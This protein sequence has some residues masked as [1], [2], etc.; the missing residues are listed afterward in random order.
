MQNVTCSCG[1]ILPVIPG[2]EGKSMPCPKCGQSVPFPEKEDPP[3]AAKDARNRFG[4][5][6]VSLDLI[7]PIQLEKALQEQKTLADRAER[8]LLGEILLKKDF[9]TAEGVRRVL[10]S[11]G[12]TLYRCPK[13]DRGYNVRGMP[14]GRRFRCKNCG[15]MI[16]G[17]DR[18]DD[19][20]AVASFAVTTRVQPKKADAAPPKAAEDKPPEPVEEKGLEVD[21]PPSIE[22]KPDV[23]P[24]LIP[25]YRIEA[26]LGTGGMGGVYRATQLSLRRSVAVKILSAEY[27]SDM[28]YVRRL[29]DEARSIAS[30][31]HDNIIDAIDFGE[32]GGVHY[33]VMEHVE[34]ETLSERLKWDKVLP[35]S[36]ALSYARQIAE[37]LDYARA[38]GFLHRDIKPS[39]LM[40]TPLGRVKI[41]DLGLTKSLSA[42]TPPDPGREVICSAAYA[43]PQQLMGEVVD[44]RSDIYSLG[45]TLYELLTGKRP[46]LGKTNADLKEQ[47]VSAL[48]RPPRTVNSAV[49]PAAQALVLKMLEKNPAQRFQDY[50]AII[51]AIDAALKPVAKPAAEP[52]PSTR[53]AASA[54]KFWIFA[55]SA[56][57]AAVVAVVVLLLA[58]TSGP[59]QPAAGAPAV[60]EPA[61]PPFQKEPYV[62]PPTPDRTAAKEPRKTPMVKA[63][64]APAEPVQVPKDYHRKLQM[65]IWRMNLSWVAAAYLDAKRSYVKQRTDKENARKRA[66]DLRKNM[67]RLEQEMLALAAAVREKGLEL[68]IED[69]LKA[70]DQISHFQN[71]DVRKLSSGQTANLLG[72]FVAGVR[73]GSKARVAFRRGA[74]LFEM[75]IYFDE[76]PK[77]LLTI[78]QVADLIPGERPGPEP[79]TEE[80]VAGKDDEPG[81][82]P[83]PFKEPS[84]RDPVRDAAVVLEDPERRSDAG[85]REAARSLY[86]ELARSRTVSTACAS[87]G[88]PSSRT[89]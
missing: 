69:Y 47:H 30:L 16:E 20:S 2:L 80:P 82:T 26:K 23:P 43:S 42:S 49:S 67:L 64:G 39:N 63:P 59:S 50:P 44:Q 45:V 76:R 78:M 1:N 71:R 53:P 12:K 65:Y 79:G 70:T 56:A 66:L 17:P 15:T 58:G 51:A 13:C 37:G 38:K 68:H 55:G 72:T 3:P 29:L 62:P 60:E 83:R 84:E 33:L 5:V 21:R 4:K 31:H 89:R 6:A 14:H 22:K 85:E 32:S 73:A 61:P 52:R 77:E 86:L 48:P 28:G 35:E 40:V 46:F 75:T 18:S 41:C 19:V 25:G 74:D 36:D 34:G 24:D 11:Q 87:T 88:S 8:C 10:G 27:A 9:L 7:T 57:A 81:P 54:S